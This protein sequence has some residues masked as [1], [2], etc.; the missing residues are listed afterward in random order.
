MLWHEKSEAWKEPLPGVKRRILAHSTTGL[1]VLYRIESGK[2]FPRHSHP[3][4]QFGLFLEGGG[5][6]TVGDKVWKM[7]AG[8]TYYIPPGVFHELVTD[9]AKTSVILDFFTPE[10]SD[11]AGESL[12]PDM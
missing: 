1:M 6:F 11:Y 12:E 9:N 5:D 8:D 4:A 10:R 3:H 2:V 7:R